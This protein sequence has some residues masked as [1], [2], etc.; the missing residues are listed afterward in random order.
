MFHRKFVQKIKTHILCSV[1]FFLENR[2][3]YEKMWQNIVASTTETT[4]IGR[5]SDVVRSGLGPDFVAL[6][7]VLMAMQ[8]N[9]HRLPL[10]VFTNN[11]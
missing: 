6:E 11:Y 2:A 10:I 3:V 7:G 9:F 1:T 8:C 5:I 4:L